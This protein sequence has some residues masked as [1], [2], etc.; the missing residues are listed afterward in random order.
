MGI[1]QN[2]AGG[3]WDNAKK[4]F[5]KGV[6]VAGKMQ[7]KGSE[8]HKAS[9]TGDTV[10]DPFKDTSGPSMNI[11]IK[12]MSIVSLVIAPHISEGGHHATTD[13]DHSQAT[14]ILV[15]DGSLQD[16]TFAYG[17]ESVLRWNASKVGGSHYGNVYIS[18]GTI[19]IKN[20][21]I[22]GGTMTVNMQS[23]QVLDIENQEDKM[24]LEGHLRSEDFFA[25]DAFPEAIIS[26]QPAEYEGM[27]QNVVAEITI[28]GITKEVPMLISLSPF[29]DGLMISS[30]IMIDRTE[31]GIQYK[32]K[33]FDSLLDNFIY[34]E[35]EVKAKIDSKRV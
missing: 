29:D 9:V 33:K 21:K 7:Y 5:E 28:K 23:I 25:V 24:K 27:E 12:L 22:V 15:N 19:E 34:D 17:S 31:F 6:M 11:L 10:G 18:N 13:A 32:S 3:A 20:G 35:F 8:P 4:S 2:N 26:L 1:F 16:G 30:S 14:E